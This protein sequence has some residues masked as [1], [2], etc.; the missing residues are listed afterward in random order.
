M[1][2]GFFMVRICALLCQRMEAAVL[3]HLKWNINLNYRLMLSKLGIT[4]FSRLSK[5]QNIQF[6]F[7]AIMRETQF[8]SL[9]ASG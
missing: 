1:I 9:H 4:L 8:I 5:E 6:I 2:I 3:M 7:S